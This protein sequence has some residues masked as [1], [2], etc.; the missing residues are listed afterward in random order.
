[1]LILPPTLPYTGLRGIDAHGG[2]GYGAPRG[3]R[4]HGG[5]D[6]AA[7]PGQCVVSPIRARV[8]RIGIAYVDNPDTLMDESELASIHLR[9]IGEGVIRDCFWIKLL[10]ALPLRTLRVGDVVPAGKIIA[11]AQDRVSFYSSKA[12][13]AVNH[14]HEEVRIWDPNVGNWIIVNPANV[15][16]FPK[17]DV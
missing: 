9:S 13:P 11:E 16:E 1:M 2:G 5:L 15:T 7:E 3:A 14:I 8:S 6:F 17:G 4:A 10:Y 12:M